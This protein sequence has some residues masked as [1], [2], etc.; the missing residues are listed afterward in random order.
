MAVEDH[1]ADLVEVSVYPLYDQ[2]SRCG[3]ECCAFSC[4]RLVSFVCLASKGGFGGSKSTFGGGG[5]LGSSPMQKGGVG[6]SPGFGGAS[7]GGLG[8][9]TMNKGMTGIPGV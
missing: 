7:P 3:T 6:L 4:K 8:G 5:G 2:I 9:S 1:Q